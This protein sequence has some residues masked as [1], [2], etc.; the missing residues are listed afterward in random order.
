MVS[1]GATN[2]THI[3]ADGLNFV[4]TEGFLDDLLRADFAVRTSYTTSISS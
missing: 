2:T 1:V 3:E 4:V